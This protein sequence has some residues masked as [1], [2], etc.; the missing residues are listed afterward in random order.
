MRI[1]TSTKPTILAAAIVTAFAAPASAIVVTQTLGATSQASAGT[2]TDTPSSFLSPGYINSNAYAST[3]EGSGSANAFANQHGAYAV[4]A[5]AEGIAAGLSNASLGYSILND[6]SSTQILSITFKIYGGYLSTN[7]TGGQTLTGA[8]TLRS[9]Y[10]ASITRNGSAYFSSSAGIVQNAGGISGTKSGVNLNTADDGSDGIY[11]WDSQY[12]TIDLGEVA[13]GASASV[14]A[15]LSHEAQSNVGTY[16]FDCG[17]VG[18]DSFTSFAAVEE[19]GS[20]FKGRS[21]GFYGDPANLDATT[22]VTEPT[23]FSFRSVPPAS[24]PLPGS[25]ALG[26]FGLAALAASRRKK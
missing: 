24:V 4:N 16:S 2:T 21:D 13:A 18:Y 11:S 14:L 25:F 5:R 22:G 1:L 17:S 20:C 9:S 12:I 6:T 7:V 8:E 10:A 23:V 26:I 15:Q 3:A 19:G